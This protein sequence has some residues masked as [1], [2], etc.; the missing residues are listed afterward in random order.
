M[1]RSILFLANL[2]LTMLNN[3]FFSRFEQSS[4]LRYYMKEVIAKYLP[5]A[6]IVFEHEENYLINSPKTSF[7]NWFNKTNRLN[8]AY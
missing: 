5:E 1:H 4:K 7:L 8:R 3:D 2:F 6:K